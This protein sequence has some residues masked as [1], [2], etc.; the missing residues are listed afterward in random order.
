MEERGLQYAPDRNECDRVVL[1]VQTPHERAGFIRNLP[2][3][4]GDKNDQ[5]DGRL[6]PFFLPPV[7]CRQWT[8]QAGDR[9]LLDIFGR[10][11][12][13]ALS[14]PSVFVVLNG[15]QTVQIDPLV[16]EPLIHEKIHF[17]LRNAQQ[18]RGCIHCL[19]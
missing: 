4:S 2:M 7:D 11:G 5:M 18:S 9:V 6:R 17:F 1:F 3:D 8:R 16:G 19:P 10:L 14:P 15:G 12:G 13:R